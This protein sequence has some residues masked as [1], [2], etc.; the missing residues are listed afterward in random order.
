MYDLFVRLSRLLIFITMKRRI[1]GQDAT[2]REGGLLI[3]SNHLGLL[4]PLAIGTKLPR[5]LYIFAKAEVFSWPVIGWLARKADVIP[6]RRGQSD[7]E[8]IRRALDYLQAGQ[9]VMFF[10][11]GTYPK[12]HQPRGMIKALPGAALLA[13]RSGAAILPIGISGSEMVW[14]PRSMPWGLFR[15]WL[16]EVRVG[17]PYR[18]TIPTTASQKQAL[19]L[20]AEE[21]MLRIAALLPESYQGHYRQAAAVLEQGQPTLAAQSTLLDPAES[22]ASATGD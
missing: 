9:A 21:M 10:P 3:V 5:R 19:A 17:A 6:V 18:P 20:I 22:D 2:P 7:R 8:A 11:E 12:S 16:V 15:R 4:D 13:Q 1:S 14:S